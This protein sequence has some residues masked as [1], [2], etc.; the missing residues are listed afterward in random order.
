MQALN[1]DNTIVA[2]STFVNNLKACWNASFVQV[3]L[4]SYN[5]K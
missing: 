4:V 2:S 1:L 5:H 3:K